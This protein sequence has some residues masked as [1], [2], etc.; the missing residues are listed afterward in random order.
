MFLF[1]SGYGTISKIGVLM[2][3]R[4]IWEIIKISFVV[5]FNHDEV[6]IFKIFQSLRGIMDCV[7]VILG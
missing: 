5:V 6:L 4:G 3:S 2:I 1:A 7:L